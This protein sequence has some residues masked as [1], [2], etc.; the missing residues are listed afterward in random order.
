M[1]KKSIS[2]EI[3]GFDENFEVA[4]NDIDLCLKVR[5]LRYLNVWIPYAR[6]YH[7][8]SISREYEYTLEKQERFMGILIDLRK[9]G[10]LNLNVEIRIIMLT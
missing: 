8:E 2:E 5:R 3:N 1:I 7:Y 6:D 4:F 10:L 9:N